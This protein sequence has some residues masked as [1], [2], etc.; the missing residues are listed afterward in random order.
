MSEKCPVCRGVAYCIEKMETYQCTGLMCH[1]RC[2]VSDLEKIREAMAL[3]KDKPKP[4]KPR[5]KAE[6]ARQCYADNRSAAGDR[7]DC[8]TEARKDIARY[9]RERPEQSPRAVTWDDLAREI[10]EME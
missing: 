7:E 1:F 3:L 4:W 2:S 8:V 9:I 6:I 5:T 10:E